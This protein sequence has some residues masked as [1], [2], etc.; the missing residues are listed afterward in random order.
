[1]GAE[2]QKLGG[3]R[4]FSLTRAA[5]ASKAALKDSVDARVLNL[6]PKPC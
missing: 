6:P 2:K 4:R 5:T 1:M 3:A